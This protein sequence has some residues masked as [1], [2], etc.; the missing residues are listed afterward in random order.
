MTGPETHKIADWAL[1][2]YVDG[3]AAA[4]LRAEV[5]ATLAEDRDA[6]E[7]VAALRQQKQMIK[8]AYASV[9]SEPIPPEIMV[10]LRRR[11]SRPGL[12][13]AVMAA[14]LAL[15][16]AGGA[17]GWFAAHR[18]GSMEA[19]TLA[20]D[21]LTAHEIY[22]Q[23]IRHPVE[24]GADESDHLASWLSKRLG[25]AFKIPD[26]N[27]E[28]YTL[29]GGRL[30]AAEGRP[31]AQLMYEDQAKRRITLF[32]IS[33]PGNSDAAIRI[34]QEGPLSAC[35]WL[36]GP[37]GFAVAGELDRDRMMQLA[38]AVYQQFEG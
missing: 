23:E 9:L 18:P 38:H 16:I 24:V 13:F 22:A 28:G 34:E 37:L 7:T 36:D 5:E 6:A 19:E 35:Y 14:S 15:L 25:H 1:Q 8:D 21:A 11:P 33:N 32:L 10:S 20:R 31:A 2:A 27:K 12:P 17:L 26:L 29:L 30:L 3:E 4:E